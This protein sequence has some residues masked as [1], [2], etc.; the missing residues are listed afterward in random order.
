MLGA[1]RIGNASVNNVGGPV[2]S[3]LAEVASPRLCRLSPAL[4]VTGR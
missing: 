1:M 3:Y 4:I 2:L